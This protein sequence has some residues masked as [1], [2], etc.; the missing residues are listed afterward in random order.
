MARVPLDEKK[1]AACREIA[2]DVASD[3]QRYIDTHTSVGAERT[4]LRAYGVDG[5]DDEGAPL[6]NVAIDRVHKLGLLGRGISSFVGASLA[7]GASSPQDAAERIAYAPVLAGGDGAENFPS[8]K[9][10]AR[11]LAPHAKAAIDRIDKARADREAR[12][13]RIL[14]SET[15]L[16]YVIVATGNIY[17][18]AVQCPHCGNYLSQEDSPSGRPWWIIVCAVLCLIAA[19]WWIAR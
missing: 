7:A 5:V 10:L 15:P 14:P 13:A 8:E 9:D 6:V 12:K 4:I 11:L 18:D 19:L 16:K 1:A 17:D 2:G 3:V